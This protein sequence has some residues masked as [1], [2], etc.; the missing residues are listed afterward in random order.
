[1]RPTVVVDLE[2]TAAGREAAAEAV[3][4]V[5]STWLRG[6]AIVREGEIVGP[7]EYRAIEQLGLEVACRRWLACCGPRSRW[8]W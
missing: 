3:P 8:S 4:E 6:Q 5:V 2:R 7:A 1:M